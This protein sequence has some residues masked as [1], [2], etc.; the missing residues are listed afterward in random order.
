MMATQ[1]VLKIVIIVTLLFRWNIVQSLGKSLKAKM[2]LTNVVEHIKALSSLLS[3][4]R[5]LLVIPYCHS[6]NGDTIRLYRLSR[7]Q[8][9]DKITLINRKTHGNTGCLENS[10]NSYFIIQM[11]HRL[12]AI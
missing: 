10:F 1:F 8:E 5:N 6:A 11:E 2:S 9:I 3:L 12:V 4:S 7:K